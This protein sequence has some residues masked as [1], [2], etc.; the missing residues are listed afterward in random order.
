MNKKSHDPLLFRFFTEIGIIDQL[1]RA[2]FESVMPDGLKMSHFIVL[3]H[4]VRLGGDWSPVR[5][6]NA[7]QVTKAAMTNTVQRL[8]A[9]GLVKVVP[10]PHDGRGKLIRLTAAGRK[11]R[12]RCVKNTAPI[13]AELEARIDKKRFAKALPLL[14]EV[15][16]YLDQHR[17]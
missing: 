14:E 6:A 1:G 16:I 15:R 3:N 9:R 7:F 4:L 5:L 17:T 8:E 10:D 2:K 11:M 13:L 12:E